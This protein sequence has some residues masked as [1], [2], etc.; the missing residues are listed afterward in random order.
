[1]RKANCSNATSAHTSKQLECSGHHAQAAAK[2]AGLLQ[3][4]GC[5]LG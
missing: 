3:L 2:E 5:R 1:M 4:A